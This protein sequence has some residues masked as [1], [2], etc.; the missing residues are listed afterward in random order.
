M[1]PKERTITGRTVLTT[2]ESRADMKVPTPTET[3]T[4]HS[5]PI[6]SLLDTDSC[7]FMTASSQVETPGAVYASHRV[8]GRNEAEP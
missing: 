3:S 7:G 2:L 5:R 1:F 4:H 6:R 8:C